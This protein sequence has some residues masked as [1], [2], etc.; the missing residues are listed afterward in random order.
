MYELKLAHDA[1]NRISDVAATIEE[2]IERKQ[3]WLDDY[4]AQEPAELTSAGALG[5]NILID[6]LTLNIAELHNIRDHL[7]AEPK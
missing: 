2:V 5:R 4:I 6:M 1:V 3:L 7:L